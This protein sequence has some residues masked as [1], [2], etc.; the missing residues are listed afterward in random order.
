[1]DS[2]APVPSPR[3]RIG[4]LRQSS[5]KR[6]RSLPNLDVLKTT[7]AKVLRASIRIMIK[8]GQDQGGIY[9]EISEA[10]NCSTMGRLGLFRKPLRLGREGL[11]PFCLLVPPELRACVS[12][13]RQTDVGPQADWCEV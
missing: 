5:R 12:S 7:R 3:G 1:M 9:F 11:E 4:F 13:K 2:A 10:K 8:R 6:L